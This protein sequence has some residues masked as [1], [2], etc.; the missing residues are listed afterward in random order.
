MVSQRDTIFMEYSADRVVQ[1]AINALWASG[2]KVQDVYQAEHIIKAKKGISWK[3]WGEHITV[4]VSA[5]SL[6]Q[7]V[8]RIES[9]ASWPLQVIDWGRNAE[10]IDAFEAALRTALQ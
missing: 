2:A 9:R 7:S 6:E 4:L 10:N 1:A 8:V 5:M 3:S